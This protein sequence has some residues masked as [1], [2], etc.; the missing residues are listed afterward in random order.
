LQTIIKLILL[1]FTEI[2]KIVFG[3]YAIVIFEEI[4]RFYSLKDFIF[5]NFDQIKSLGY[6]YELGMVLLSLQFNNID[7]SFIFT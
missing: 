3:F 1:F 5:H 7:F 4:V 2:K 6:S